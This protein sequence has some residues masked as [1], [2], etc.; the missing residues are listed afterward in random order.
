MT[1]EETGPMMES[2]IIGAEI[3]GQGGSRGANG[4]AASK[5]S[6]RETGG[7]LSDCTDRQYQC[8]AIS[9]PKCKR[10]IRGRFNF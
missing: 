8:R 7:L 2:M 3:H 10:V 5:S 6:R 9:Q 1:E 4:N